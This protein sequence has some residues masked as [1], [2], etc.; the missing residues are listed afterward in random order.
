MW[1]PCFQME[2]ATLTV[3]LPEEVDHPVSEVIRRETDRYMNER[4]VRRLIFDF[5]ETSF[6]DSSGIGMIMGRFRALGMQKDCVAAV[7]V[8]DR[9]EKLLRLSGVHRY[10]RIEK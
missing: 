6:M 2:N 8:S 5:K 4:Y 3:K 9:L 1:K 7:C 10:I